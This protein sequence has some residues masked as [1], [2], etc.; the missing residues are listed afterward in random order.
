MI[1]Q[2]KWAEIAAFAMICLA[3]IKPPTPCGRRNSK[4]GC[5]QDKAFVRI[6]YRKLGCPSVLDIRWLAAVAACLVPEM[7]AAQAVLAP[8]RAVYD[9]TLERSGASA[10]I[11][12]LTGRMVFELKGNAC[13]G[14]EQTMRFVTETLDRN[15]KTSVTDQRSTFYENY[16][17]SRFRF[18]TDQYRNDRLS[19]KTRGVA[20][21]AKGPA[22][23]TVKIKSPTPK[24]LNIKRSVVFPVEHS[25][26]L[27]EAA[28]SGVKLFAADLFDGSEKGEKVYATTAA[29]GERQAPGINAKLSKLKG[30]ASLDKLAAWPVSLSYF[31]IDGKR[32][33]AVPNYELSFIYFEN[34]VSRK[35]FIDYGTFSMRGR[36]TNLT[37]LPQ[38]ACDK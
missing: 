32:R 1:C 9:M 33:D 20:I 28:Q 18:E 13:T 6:L 2:E 27:L 29:L 15:G 21:R 26:R 16:R 34:G 4:A 8:H 19:S 30:A 7:V 17:K 5:K 37:M 14:F 36:L 10:G 3:S 31:K 38:K 11:S 35:L 25:V 24:Q 22:T 23:L 12:A